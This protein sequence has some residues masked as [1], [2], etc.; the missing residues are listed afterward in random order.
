MQYKLALDVGGTFIKSA[1]VDTEGMIIESTLGESPTNSN[2][3]PEEI[4]DSFKSILERNRSLAS[5]TEVGICIPGP[6]DYENG[7]FNMTQKFTSV[8]GMSLSPVFSAEG[9]EVKYLHDSTAFLLGEIAEGAARGF[10]RPCGIML[11]TGFGFTMSH[12]GRILIN[13]E[14]RPCFSLWNKKF[15][16]GIVEDT[17]SR[18]AI[19]ERYAKLSGDFSMPDVREI[20]ALATGGDKNALAVFRDVGESIG[21]VISS[22]IP[23]KA[24]DF[25]VMGGQ[26]SKAFD[27]MAPYIGLEIP[28][29][30]AANI[31]DAA[32][33]GVGR[34]LALG[35]DACTRVTTEKEA[36]A[37][38]S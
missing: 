3:K 7:I 1:L 38:W 31:S 13:Q 22:Y 36:L 21:E 30:R 32:I 15:R 27:L 14:Q 16:D 5:F 12:G 17:I 10:D 35:K 24:Y 9:L 23:K 19:R 34:Y 33:R 6:F 28:V 37:C 11:G 18:K 29:S 25:L 8:R 4:L 26:I 20:A 2:G